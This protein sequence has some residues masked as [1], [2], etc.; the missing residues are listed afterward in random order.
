MDLTDE[1]FKDYFFRA[2]SNYNPD[3]GQILARF[4]AKADFV[5]DWMK[6]N[7]IQLLCSNKNGAE[8]A[9]RIMK[10]LVSATEKDAI[11]VLTEIATDLLGGMTVDEVVDKPYRF[12][13]EQFYW[14]QKEYVPDIPNWEIIS[15]V[16][17]RGVESKI[18]EYENVLPN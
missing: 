3:K 8:S 4:R 12:T 16:D 10:K 1:N 2:D 14:T 6:R 5:D 7:V 15:T 13:L 11:R 9:F 17:T 18:L